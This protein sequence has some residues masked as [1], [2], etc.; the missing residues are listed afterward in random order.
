[1][2]AS[3]DKSPAIISQ[4]IE[5]LIAQL[6][7]EGVEAGREEADRLIN[8]ANKKASEILNEAQMKSQ[9]LLEEVHQ[10]ILLEKKAA[11]D[12]LQLAAR[13][14][15]LELRQ[16]LMHRFAEEIGRITRKELDNEAFLRQLIL[17]IAADTKEQLQNFKSNQVD[18][19]L[20]GKVLSFE[21]IR[22]ILI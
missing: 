14:M 4:N 16:N 11:E 19:L 6:K 9:R 1:M 2:D 5:S 13:N 8:E 18:I 20:P 21:E 10:Q 22:K 15:R 7:Q 17:M 12:A 3:Q